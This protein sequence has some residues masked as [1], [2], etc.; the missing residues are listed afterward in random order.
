[1]KLSNEIIQLKAQVAGLSKAND[2]LTTVLSKHNL[3][4]IDEA[5]K[6]FVIKEKSG[7]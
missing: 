6:Q 7:L 4:E 1:M 5:K 2:F 3:I